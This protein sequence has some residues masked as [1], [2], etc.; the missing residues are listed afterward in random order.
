MVALP[1]FNGVSGNFLLILHPRPLPPYKNNHKYT[2]TVKTEQTPNIPVVAIYMADKD[3]QLESNRRRIRQPPAVPFLWEEQP[4]I[5]KKEWK[6]GSHSPSITSTPSSPQPFIKAIDYVPF[7]WDEI[8]ETQLVSFSPPHH[9][10]QSITNSCINLMD[11]PLPLPPALISVRGGETPYYERELSSKSDDDCDDHEA[12]HF[13]LF[14]A[15]DADFGQENP[16]SKSDIKQSINRAPVARVPSRPF[17]LVGSVPF[18]WEAKPGT[19]LHS[20]SWDMSETDGLHP[21]E[22]NLLL[23]PPPT[24]YGGHEINH[25]FEQERIS[26]LETCLEAVKDSAATR[27]PFC[28]VKFVASVP[29]SWE[30]KPGKPLPSWQFS[31][32]DQTT[33][34]QTEGHQNNSRHYDEVF[35]FD[36][37]SFSFDTDESLSSEPS[38]MANCLVASAAISTAVPVQTNPFLSMDEVENYPQ[39]DT[40]SYTESSYETEDAGFVGSSLLEWLFPNFPPK[41]EFLEKNE[42]C[43]RVPEKVNP[44]EKIETEPIDFGY[45][46]HHGSFAIRKPKTLGELIMMSRRR[47][48][49][50]KAAQVR[51][52]NPS[53][54]RT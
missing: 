47:S 50:R 37:E 22:A 39:L 18:V 4:G 35:E 38:L 42:S 46:I 11:S 12:N 26:N 34:N 1:N 31:G 41:S 5:P 21:P 17:K 6:I 15:G 33:S 19:P 44:P 45:S 13:E 54:V 30:E 7:M 52:Q 25:V 48:Y 10:H 20:F 16:F 24:Y 28:P 23:L 40:S 49:V 43:K 53:M 27:I 8:P 2:S 9:I 36:V 51:K 29:F 3:P 14:Q 32:T